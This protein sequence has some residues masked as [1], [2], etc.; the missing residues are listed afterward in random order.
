LKTDFDEALSNVVNLDFVDSSQDEIPDAD[1]YLIDEADLV[2][3]NCK[4]DC[5]DTELKGIFKLL[6]KRKTCIFIS[7]TYSANDKFFLD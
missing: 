1:V 3:K 5:S 6:D 4:F 2:I 7:A